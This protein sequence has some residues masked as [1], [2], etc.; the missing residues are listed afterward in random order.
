M[1][2]R[3]SLTL[4]DRL[5]KNI[6][7][8]VDDRIITSRSN[9]IEIFLERYL[10]QNRFCVILAGGDHENLYVKE[11]DTYRPLLSING[12]TIIENIM[13]KASKILYNKFIVIGSS[14]IIEEIKK[15]TG[16]YDV[17]YI[18]ENI[19]G[20]TG[21]TLK[22]AEKMI[23]DTFLFVPCDHYFDFDL[24]NIERIHFLNDFS[25]TLA[26]YAATQPLER[27]GSVVDLDGNEIIG[28]WEKPKKYK[29]MLEATLIGFAE[30]SIFNL[31]GKN[32]S[33]LQEDVF[34]RLIKRRQLGGGIVSGSFANVHSLKDI[35]NIRVQ[36]KIR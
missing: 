24:K 11:A 16:N 30:P 21:N 28:Y 20:K 5:I 19:V 31:I 33:S 12:R 36:F 27:I 26:V 32:I 23:K 6:D 7:R 4:E 9:A 34:P 10:S 8:Y 22:L 25:A 29:T 1:K 35:D 3:I 18:E 15:V 13:E 14:Q 17:T 2:R